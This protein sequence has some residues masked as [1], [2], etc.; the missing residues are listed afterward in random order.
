MKKHTFEFI[1]SKFQEK[2]CALLEKTY[3]NSTHPM[4]YR[5]SCGLESTITYRDFKERGLCKGSHTFSITQ[6]D[7]EK[8][9]KEHGCKLLDEYVNNRIDM[10]YIC[11][12]GEQFKIAMKEF[13]QGKRCKKCGIEKSS[14]TRTTD[15]QDIKKLFEQRQYQLLSTSYTAGDRL[16]SICP[17][18]HHYTTTLQGF[19]SG[20]GCG[21]CASLNNTGENNPNWNPDREQVELNKTIWNRWRNLLRAGFIN[22]TRV[23]NPQTEAKLGYS[24]VE[25]RE[26][27]KKHPNWEIIN[28]GKFHI[29]HV[30]PVHA[31]HKVGITDVKYICALD[32][33]QPIS[34]E[35]NRKKWHQ[36]DEQAFVDY[37]KSKNML[38]LVI[39]NEQKNRKN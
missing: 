12:C 10:K 23:Q 8:Y 35:Q 31:F 3:V 2:Q 21:K 14:K 33:L 6:Q 7:A 27:L 32:N 16:I 4:K 26:H 20:Y 39:T 34:P 13:K 15:F 28:G 1:V 29:D 38:Q 11:C 24:W 18:G 30:F 37:L 19:K 9:F 25:L 36:Y 22:P 5:C 17:S